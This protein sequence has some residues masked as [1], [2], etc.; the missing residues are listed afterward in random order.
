MGDDKKRE[1]T[2]ELENEGE[3]VTIKPEVIVQMTIPQKASYD[4][5]VG[6]SKDILNGNGP[7]TRYSKNNMAPCKLLR[8]QGIANPQMLLISLSRMGIVWYWNEK[9]HEYETVGPDNV[10]LLE[11]ECILKVTR[12]H[13]NELMIGQLDAKAYFGDEAEEKVKSELIRFYK[14][15][16]EMPR[17]DD[18]KFKPGGNSYEVLRKVGFSDRSIKKFWLYFR[19]IGIIEETGTARHYR[20][21]RPPVDFAKKIDPAYSAPVEGFDGIPTVEI[22]TNEGLLAI[23]TLLGDL[24][25]DARTLQSQLNVTH[26]NIAKAKKQIPIA[27]EGIKSAREIEKI[28]QSR[29]NNKK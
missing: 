15:L 10:E 14:F 4:A 25:K 26:S 13:V 18:G 24:C 1:Q 9:Q 11:C 2:E 28:R 5:L 22:F 12:V 27:Y 23:Y 19:D 17:E 3:R 20:R 16:E 7:E 8:S 29:E 21:F 6:L